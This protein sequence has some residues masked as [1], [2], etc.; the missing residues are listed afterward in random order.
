MDVSARRF[1]GNRLPESEVWNFE[2]FESFPEPAPFLL[3]GMQRNVNPAPVVESE[4]T[5]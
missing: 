5:V 3:V 4:R 2:G 1:P